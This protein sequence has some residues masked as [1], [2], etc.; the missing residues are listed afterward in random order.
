MYI[1]E[2]V[3]LWYS[4]ASFG[5]I[6]ISAIIRS[7]GST[8]PRLLR[9]WQIDVQSGCTGQHSEQQQRSVPLTPNLHQHLLSS[10]F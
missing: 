8:I 1:D 2:H 5:Y 7:C 6:P 3:S 4:G 10:D 9:N